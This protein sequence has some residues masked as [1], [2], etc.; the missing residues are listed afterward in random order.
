[1][2]AKKFVTLRARWL[3]FTFG[4]ETLYLVRTGTNGLV[5]AGVPSSKGIT[6]FVAGTNGAVTPLPPSATEETVI[7]DLGQWL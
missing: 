1:M 7:Q 4:D 6:Y 2:S 3:P 5:G